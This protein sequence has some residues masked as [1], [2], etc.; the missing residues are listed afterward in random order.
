MD[1]KTVATWMLTELQNNECIYQDDVVDF[2]IKSK[3]ESLLRENSDGNQVLNRQLLNE[4]KKLTA[5][6]VVW[7]SPDLYWRFRVPEDEE[8]R[9]AKG[10][11]RN[12]MSLEI[13][14]YPK[15]AS[16]SKLIN[17]LKQNDFIKSEH[18]LKEMNTSE[19]LHYHWFNDNDCVSFD[20][21]E[22]TIYKISD[23]EKMKN[24][25]SEWIL[26]TRTTASA[27]REDKSQQ[28]NI[29]KKARQIFKGTFYNDWY[30][31][32]KYTDINDYQK[33]SSPERCLTLMFNNLDNKINSLEFSLKSYKSP[34]EAQ[35]SNITDESIL[36]L[37]K[38]QDPSIVLFNS[39]IPFLV[40]LIEYL[41]SQ[42]FLILIKYNTYAQSEIQKETFKVSFQDALNIEKGLLS[43]EELITNNFTFQNMNHTNKAFKKYL[44][45]D[46][47]NIFSK[48]KKIDNKLI[49]LNIKLEEIIEL[50]HS[51]I[52][53]F[54]YDNVINK[55][56]FEKLFNII[57]NVIETFL[58]YLEKENNW[59]LRD[60]PNKTLER[61]SLP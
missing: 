13:T 12:I 14:L 35:L 40:S 61:N 33:L 20:G 18:Y 51:M 39:M 21:V 10:Y 25:C 11:K 59:T 24:N 55:E 43:T 49:R 2:I 28:N 42:S 47:L 50:R 17:F 27:S 46:I 31:T 23:D 30:G 38:P 53:H 52:H 5:T 37:I 41:F 7:V 57:K 8:G 19:T 56:E 1:A 54:G 58:E 32:N 36:N 48:R 4:F 22:A 60:K 45:I 6:D 34:F 29:I 16:K 3:D 26:H 15:Q 9:N 44:N